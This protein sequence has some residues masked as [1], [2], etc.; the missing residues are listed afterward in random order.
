MERHNFISPH[1]HAGFP[2]TLR[3]RYLLR[4]QNLTTGVLLAG[5]GLRIPLI[6][7]LR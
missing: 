7:A 4:I 1:S 5:L 2:D 3:D 6:F